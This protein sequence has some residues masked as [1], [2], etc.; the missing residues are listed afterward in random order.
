MQKKYGQARERGIDCRCRR[1]EQKEENYTGGGKSVTASGREEKSG[2]HDRHL[3]V[4][5]VTL[6]AFLNGHRLAIRQGPPL[7]GP[8]AAW[9]STTAA[10]SGRRGRCT[11]R[12]RRR[13]AVDAP[14]R[15]R[16][17]PPRRVASRQVTAL[18]TLLARLS[19]DNG[20]TSRSWCSWCAMATAAIGAPAAPCLAFK[21]AV[22]G[23]ASALCQ[24]HR[25]LHLQCTH[26]PPH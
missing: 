24:D 1:R 9:R 26:E 17:G 4:A 14:G 8:V 13:L 10:V 25:R 3:A 2:L 12:T 16:P 19:D 23:T 7:R 11:S 5:S 22:S 18:C 15:A 21:S 6:E 20:R